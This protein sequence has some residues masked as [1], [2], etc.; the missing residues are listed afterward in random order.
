MKKQLQLWFSSFMLLC[1][2][3]IVST[4]YAQVN[5]SENFNDDEGGWDDLD[6]YSTSYLSCDESSLFAEFYYYNDPFFGELSYAPETV[7]PLLGTSNGLP[8]TLTYS[9]KLL[10]YSDEEAVT[11][12]VDW[13][14]FTV[15]YGPSASG[16]WTLLQTI[17]NTNHV[18]S[19]DC[20]VKT[21]NFTP[22]TGTGVYL[23]VI[24]TPGSISETDIYFFLDDVSVVQELLPCDGTPPASAAVAASTSICNQENAMLSLTPAYT[25]SGLTFQWQKSTDGITYTDVTTDG[26]SATLSIAQTVPTWYKATITCTASTLSVTSTPVQ[27]LNSGLNCICEVEFNY[28]I[29]PI[30]NVTFAS[31]DNTSSNEVNAWP[32]VEDYSSLPPAVVTKGMTYPIS[33]EGNTNGATFTTYFK[34]FIDFNQNGTLDD[35]GESF[36]IGSITGSTGTDGQA[37]TGTIQIPLTATTGVTYMRVFKLYN[38]YPDSPCGTE[39]FGYGQVEDYLLD[40]QPCMTEAPVADAAQTLCGGSTI[41]DIDVTGTAVKWYAAETGGSSLLPTLALTDGTTYYAT[42]TEGCESLTR[43]PVTVTITTVPVDDPADVS[44]CGSYILPALTNGAYY[45]EMNGE[46]DVVAA[47]TEITETT[48][49]YVYATSGTCSAENAFTVTI[50]SAQADAPEDVTSCGVYTLPEL[51]NGNYYTA[52]GGTGDMLAAGT[53]VNATTTLYVYAST[54]PTCFAENS[55]TITIYNAIADE[56]DDVTA[57]GSYILPELTNG[58]Y[59][60]AAG[61]QGEILEA[62]DVIEAS[63]TIYIYAESGDETTLC[64]AENSFM[65]TILNAMVDEMEDVTAC[66]SYILP[67]LTNGNYYTGGSGLGEMLMAGDA[68]TETST[69]HIY[70]E[71][72]TEPNICTAESSFTITIVNVVAD[73]LEDVTTCSEYILPELENGTYFTESDGMGDELSAGDAIDESMMVY[74]YAMSES[75]MC[76]D[77]TSFMVTVA[78]VDAPTGDATIE[79]TLDAT[80]GLFLYEVELEAEGTIT[81]YA[82]E[83]DAEN[84]TNPLTE[85]FIVPVGTNTYYATQT[86]GECESEPFEVTIDVLLSNDKFD[87]ASFSYYPNPVSDVLNFNYSANITGVEVFNLLGQ[88][89]IVKSFNQNNVQLNV[90]QLAAGTYM[91]KVST[92]NASKII[93]VVKK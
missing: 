50:G 60:T 8:A 80:G 55:F 78:D 90:S 47:G 59:F 37:A 49:L 69:V 54:S 46:G 6:F 30:T 63:G 16:P 83:E 2:L 79:Y 65:V 39:D 72:G 71:E 18:S 7:S 89:I 68:I 23:R 11:N 33:L 12:D 85:D 52:T 32:A 24:A 13:G 53:T 42:Q 93:K 75:G 9:Y 4:G 36:E 25:S 26:T 43:T 21:V 15:E 62:G 73:Q 61:G 5:Y 44:D 77:E 38:V 45:T 70:A 10:N 3:G 40:I 91:V 56:M 20:A 51:T 28:D 82:T 29:E 17:N 74:I 76:T 86:V 48:T 31:I 57:C 87:S 88:Q 84:G 35:D 34:V 19:S 22:P 66:G 27:V 81:W 1:A 64:T 67:E 58:V 14:N 41:A 92:E